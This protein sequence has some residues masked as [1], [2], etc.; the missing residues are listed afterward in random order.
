MNDIALSQLCG[1]LEREFKKLRELSSLQNKLQT[2]DLLN[3]LNIIEGTLA[4]IN[5]LQTNDPTFKTQYVSLQT[6]ISN[7]RTFLQRENIYGQEYI[8]RQIQ[9]L[10]DKIEALLV[11][12]KPEGFIPRLNE[13]ITKHSQFSENWAVAMC[14]LG[15]MEVALNRFLEKFNVNLEEFRV[16]KHS[17]NNNYTFGDKYYGFCRYLERHGIY[18]SKFE[19]ELPKAFYRI[20]NEVVHEGYSPNDKDLE[21]IIKCS[22]RIVDLI[23]NAEKKLTEV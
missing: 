8:K 6:D 11:K 10:V 4:K 5:A 2:E 13:F 1:I 7:L 21:L 23:E 17:A 15:A 20:R 14:Y 3:A 16:K 18:L 9:Y 22:E 19:E 12:I